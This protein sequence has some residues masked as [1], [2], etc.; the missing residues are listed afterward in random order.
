VF[1]EACLP[2]E[3]L[4]LHIL[5]LDLQ[6]QRLNAGG[7]T[8]LV[9]KF[10]RLRPYSLTT[11]SRAHIQLVNE[12]IPAAKFQTVSKGNDHVTHGRMIATDEVDSSEISVLE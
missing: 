12:G 9:G 3:G 5:P 7:T 1:L 6:V 2:I 11:A 4:C 10:Q 8:H